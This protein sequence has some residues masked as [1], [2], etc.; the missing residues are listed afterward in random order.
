MDQPQIDLGV[1]LPAGERKVASR[2]RAA[3]PGD[4]ARRFV[5]VIASG[6]GLRAKDAHAL[7]NSILLDAGEL[8]QAA[9]VAMTLYDPEQGTI[10]ILDIGAPVFPGRIVKAGE[11][12]AGSV[13]KSG[14]PLVIDD[15]EQWPG[16]ISGD[17]LG[18]PIVSAVAVPVRNGS[19]TIGAMTAHSTDPARRFSDEDAH[20]LEVFADVAMLAVS[21]FSMHAELRT[22]NS[23]LGRRVR[24]RTRALQRSTEEISHKNE[25]L[26]A[27]I[28]A[29]GRAQNDERRRI[30][31]DIHDGVMQTLSGAIFEL[32][33]AET[34]SE[35]ANVAPKL[36]TVR[37]LLHRLE[38]ELRRVI[39]D[40][41]PVEL[42]DGGLVRAIDEEARHLQTRYGI[43]CRVRRLGRQRPLPQP[44]EVAALRIVKEALRNVQ[45]HA[46]AVLVDVEIHVRRTELRL[47]IRDYGD[48]FEPDLADD[49]HPHLGI[50]G[51][52]R[53]A[54]AAGGSF[55][56]ESTLGRGTEVAA[57]LPIEPTV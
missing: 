21:H 46:S 32:K 9:R 34:S 10:E 28:K 27:L 54:E 15:W 57:T 30:A 6:G 17:V 47:V 41:Q 36:A 51:M 50:S 7:L 45:R 29:I 24:E 18:P 1:E 52:R 39:Q 31:Q 11:G 37:E 49:E 43:R 44:V 14:H 48:G 3:V 25:Q 20:V 40:L 23:R 33:A 55:L 16:K 35:E 56:L 8:L 26:E 12:V 38:G 2:Q 53:R 4:A 22:L 42:E 5:D 19:V 13:I